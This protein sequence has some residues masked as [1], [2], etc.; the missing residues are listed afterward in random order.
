[1]N[2]NED[3]IKTLGESLQLGNK[4]D[5]FTVETPLLG[6]LPELD[7]MAV[8][9]LI[10]ALEEQFDF[11]VEDDEISADTFETVGSLCDFVSTKLNNN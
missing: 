3:V 4:T 5:S 6:N 11:T 10:T 9:T 7:S 1:M 2:V 8:I